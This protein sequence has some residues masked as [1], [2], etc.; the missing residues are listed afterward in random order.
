MDKHNNNFP[1]VLRQLRIEK[2]LTQL[3]LANKLGYKTKNTVSDWE[4]GRKT[5]VLDNLVIIAKF[6]GVSLDYLVGL[7]GY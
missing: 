6:F 3:E 5:P 1:T 4:T 7:D 2:E